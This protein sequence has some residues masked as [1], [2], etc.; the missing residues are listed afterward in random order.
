MFQVEGKVQCIKIC[1]NIKNKGK[2]PNN[3][4]VSDNNKWQAMLVMMAWR[5]MHLQVHEILSF[6]NLSSNTRNIPVHLIA[7]LLSGSKWKNTGA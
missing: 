2:S 3:D 6:C 4:S 1:E 5:K 7:K